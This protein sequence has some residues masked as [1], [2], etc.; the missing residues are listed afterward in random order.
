[1]IIPAIH[2]RLWDRRRL[3]ENGICPRGEFCEEWNR[4]RPGHIDTDLWDKKAENATSENKIA[5][6]SIAPDEPRNK[7]SNPSTKP[8]TVASAPRTRGT[9]A[10]KP[11]KHILAF[12]PQPLKNQ[13]APVPGCPKKGY[14]KASS[15]RS[16][17]GPV[18]SHVI[19]PSLRGASRPMDLFW[20][21]WSS[22]GE[23][24]SPCLCS[25]SRSM[26]NPRGENMGNNAGPQQD[27]FSYITIN[28]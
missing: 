15:Y 13:D 27:G 14:F 9:P 19:Q 18:W 2:S 1:M 4:K 6:H 28:S 26:H 3:P 21:S 24:W 12:E 25:A 17:I 8:K 5:K 20:P 7:I 11:K 16:D 23:S 10:T 22:S